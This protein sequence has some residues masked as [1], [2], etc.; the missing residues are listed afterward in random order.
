MDKSKPHQFCVTM[1]KEDFINI[2][3]ILYYV[4]ELQNFA[5][6]R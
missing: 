2:N 1:V 5:E 6:R 4:I 3:V